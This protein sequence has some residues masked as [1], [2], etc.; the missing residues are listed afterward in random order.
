MVFDT[1]FTE[2]IGKTNNFHECLCFEVS[3]PAEDI[4]QKSWNLWT[5]LVLPIV[6]MNLVA[7]R[8]ETIGKPNKFHEF[9]CFEVSKPSEAIVPEIIEIMG[10]TNSF[11]EFGSKIM[12]TIGK[13]NSHEFWYF[14]VSKPSEAIVVFATNF[15]ERI[16]FSDVFHGLWH[17]F[18]KSWL[19]CF[20]ALKRPC[21][22]NIVTTNKSLDFQDYSPQA[23]EA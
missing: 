20:N 4:V 18:G 5:L 9:W 7:K 23:A 12:G 19:F 8:M 1:R 16:G 13:T 17:L 11:H 2:K 15:M 6:S 10:F 3:K 14:E 22:R 21:A